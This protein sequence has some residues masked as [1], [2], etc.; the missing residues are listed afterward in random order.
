[1]QT[2]GVFRQNAKQISSNSNI[3]CK[4]PAKIQYCLVTIKVHS[5]SLKSAIVRVSG[6]ALLPLYSLVEYS[7]PPV[8]CH[9]VN[10]QLT[11]GT[12][13]PYMTVTHWGKIKVSP[14]HSLSAIAVRWKPLLVQRS[15]SGP[16]RGFFTLTKPFMHRAARREDNGQA[17]L[18]SSW[19]W[20]DKS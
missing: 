5:A 7:T 19:L 3:Y 14:T 17:K 1:M 10:K 2:S 4:S 11:V 12:S 16:V 20:Q 6:S 8:S 13:A 9:A 18:S 15:S